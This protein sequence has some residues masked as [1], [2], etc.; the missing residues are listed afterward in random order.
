MSVLEIETEESLLDRVF[1]VAPN[2]GDPN[3]QTNQT[4]PEGK[5]RKE[6]GSD[7]IGVRIRPQ[8]NRRSHDDE[9]KRAGAEDQKQDSRFNQS[10][11][12][13]FAGCHAHAGCPGDSGTQPTHFP[14]TIM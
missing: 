12:P 3:D 1:A 4:W 14:G 7:G 5:T 6:S 2:A 9:K 11:P 10:G 8:S 13:V